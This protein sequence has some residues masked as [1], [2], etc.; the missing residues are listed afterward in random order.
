[1][2]GLIAKLAFVSMLAFA[3]T[4][5]AY[6]P[7]GYFKNDG[8]GMIPV[9]YDLSKLPNSTLTFHINTDGLWL[10]PENHP[11]AALFADLKAALDAWNVST[12]ALRL[13]PGGFTQ[14]TKFNGPAG[15]VSFTPEIP[16]GVAVIHAY[17]TDVLP[18]DDSAAFIPLTASY[19]KLPHL[20]DE[21]G[22]YGLVNALAEGIG[23]SIG[24]NNSH[25]MGM[26]TQVVY[27][28]NRGRLSPDDV[29]GISSLYP[30]DDFDKITG[31][32]AGW[33]TDGKNPVV[34]GAVTA[35][36][37]SVAI[38]TYTNPDGT[39]LIRGLPPGTYRLFIQPLMGGVMGGGSTDPNLL[40]PQKKLGGGAVTP[41][42]NFGANFL[43][44]FGEYSYSESGARALDVAAGSRVYARIWGV[45]ERG[46]LG[47]DA[48]DAVSNPTGQAWVPSVWVQRGGQVPV[49]VGDAHKMVKMV[50]DPV[51]KDKVPTV[52]VQV[53]F[54]GWHQSAGPGLATSN[55]S[56]TVDESSSAGWF[57]S[58]LSF[59]VSATANAAPGIRSIIYVAVPDPEKPGP[60]ELYFSA[61]YVHVVAA[62]P[63]RIT[64][65]SPTSGV[66]GTAVTITGSGFTDFSKVFFDGLPATIVSSSPTS[67]VV[68]APLGAAGHGSGI[69]VNNSDGQGSDLSVNAGV[70]YVDG[71]PKDLTN[72]VRFTYDPAIPA[73][74]IAVAPTSVPSG[75]QNF[76]IR[77]IGTNTHFVQGETFVGFGAGDMVINSV[78]VSTPT[79][80]TADVTVNAKVGDGFPVTVVTGE[81]VG[82]LKD[83]L[84]VAAAPPAPPAPPPAAALPL[85]LQVVSGNG[86]VGAPGSRLP[87]PLVVK[88][89]D[90]TGKLLGGVK[91]NFSVQGGGGTVSPTSAITDDKGLASTVLTLGAAFGLNSVAATAD[92][93]QSAGFVLAGARTASGNLRLTGSGNNQTA[94]AGQQLPKPLVLTV[95]DVSTNKPLEGLPV[96]WRVS[97]GGGVV[98]PAF[99]I[100]DAS[101]TVTAQWKLGPTAGPQTLEAILSGFSPIVFRADAR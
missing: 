13:R 72:L 100:T 62:P 86:Q 32:Y 93:F 36:S 39:F 49:E 6:F 7:Y 47:M 27:I 24:L 83:A 25:I 81:E 67:L 28:N 95:V 71:K 34:L 63:P 53:G 84:R 45:P 4:S 31:Q 57:D 77:V 58:T 65:V 38:G 94:S 74:E 40:G 2:K 22:A 59:K 70:T 97:G 80:L 41:S 96:T 88:A 3:A 101:G 69:F 11:K 9:R 1:M 18:K 73:P 90:A 30:T 10:L 33:V 50:P 91:V 54:T 35:Y 44:M 20:V 66:G 46:L 60:P 26:V 51:T 78:T 64:S 19:V 55:L 85:T 76:L 5:W 14:L 52:G 98:V 8:S 43:S 37:D 92:L 61:G 82:F 75:Q 42:L 99:T 21:L 79:S 68:T 23:G 89:Q 29:A 15:L 56:G 87:A 17:E 12:S 16:P 48:F